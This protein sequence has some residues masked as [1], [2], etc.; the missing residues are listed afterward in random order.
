MSASAFTIFISLSLIWGFTWIAIKFGLDTTPP[1]F[2]A[3]TRFVTAGLILAVVARRRF[4]FVDIKA[5]WKEFL[6]VALLIT[7]LCYGPIFWGMQFTSS[8]IAAVINLSLIPLLLFALGMAFGTDTFDWGKGVGLALGIVG[9][10]VLFWPELQ[11][12]TMVGGAGVAALVFGTS[13]YCLGSVLSG[14][15]LTSF[16]PTVLSSVVMSV[17]G[18]AIFIWSLVV[19][20]VSLA[21]FGMFL[22]PKALISWLFLVIAGSAIALT[23]YLE[24]L[25]RWGPTRAGLYAFV[26]PIVALVTGALVLGE[27][28]EW[29]QLVGVVLLVSAAALVM[30][31]GGK[32]NR[33]P[34]NKKALE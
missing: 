16:H 15:W 32:G 26:S 2:F 10:A 7:T 29:I 3:G 9:L 8:G 19:E 31:R 28:L 24:L 21:T 5:K 6:V 13:A 18:L 11:A 23:M 25:R 14:K 17:G 22:D 33:P 1:L 27:R 30:G 12:G 20:P 34:P 4:V